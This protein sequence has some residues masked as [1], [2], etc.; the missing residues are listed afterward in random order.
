[1]IEITRLARFLIRRILFSIPVFFG[2][3]I[4]V[5][6][7]MYAAGD[8]V[9]L[10]LAGVPYITPEVVE[11]LRR[12][13]HL[14]RPVWEQY[15]FWVFNLVQGNLGESFVYNQPVLQLVIPWT[16][17]TVKLQLSALALA[18]FLAIF[19]G[20]YSA[21][22]PYSITDM[23]VTTLAL[24]GV[25]MPIFVWGIFGILIF[26]SYAH[27]A[28]TALFGFPI[29]FPPVGAHAWNYRTFPFPLFLADAIWHMILPMCVLAIT[30]MALYVRLVRSGM[31][32]TLEQD[33]VLAARAS[34]LSDRK[35][36]YKHALRNA[37]IPLITYVGLAIATSF[38]GAPIT[39]TVF[40]WP[41]MGYY[42]V[43]ALYSLDF[44]LIMAVISIL[45]ILILAAN[46][47]V[48][49]TYGFID[50]RITV[51]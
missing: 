46:I 4:I 12:Y 10:L 6:A 44:P 42:Y 31:R 15:L 3:T 33:Y 37:L 27:S 17:E 13:Y 22:H 39:E 16:I 9:R 21:R 24:L 14:D 26:S 32:E 49:M 1:M 23:A 40:T 48:D 51:E 47:I 8:P 11:N 45:T 29:Y 2:V 20:V 38:A 19:I 28:T 7:L 25:S 36:V 34:G 30:Y 18:L 43:Q 35:V 41:G 50:P 5:W